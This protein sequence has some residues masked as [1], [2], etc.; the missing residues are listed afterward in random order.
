MARVRGLGAA[1]SGTG[2]FIAERLTSLVLAL[3]TPYVLGFFLYLIGKPRDIVLAWVGS[4]Y[5]APILAAFMITSVVHMRMGMQAIVEDYVHSHGLKTTLLVANWIC[6]WSI[7]L[8][9][10]FAILKIFVTQA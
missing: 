8:L 1:K 5:L 10:L 3:L 6:C 7:A 4:I 9:S 2:T